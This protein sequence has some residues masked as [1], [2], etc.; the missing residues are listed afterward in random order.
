MFKSCSLWLALLL[1]PWLYGCDGFN[2]FGPMGEAGK[3][4]SADQ[5]RVE[6]LIANVQN[7][8]TLSTEANRY[9]TQGKPDAAV[10]L[11]KQAE[12]LAP[13]NGDIRVDLANALLAQKDVNLF[14]LQD[15]MTHL[16][17]TT[18]ATR[19]PKRMTGEVCSWD[20]ATATRSPFDVTAFD[21]YAMI[22]DPALQE[23]LALALDPIFQNMPY[24][25]GAQ[26]IQAALEARQVT[27]LPKAQ[28]VYATVL[29][30]REYNA[31]VQKG[32]EQSV[33]WYT[34]QNQTKTSTWIGICA[35]SR[36]Q[37]SAVIQR[38]Q[39]ALDQFEWAVLLL[40]DRAVRLQSTTSQALVKD[41][42]EGL[43]ILRRGLIEQQP[44]LG[45]ALVQGVFVSDLEA[46]Q[47]FFDA[48]G[49]T[50]WAKKTNWMSA[51]PVSTWFGVTVEQNRIVGLDLDSNQLSGVI[52][53]TF[54]QLTALK[55]LS[56]DRNQLTGTFPDALGTLT[57]LTYFSAADNALGGA[58][59]DAI[60]RWT[61]LTH[62][63]LSGQHFSGSLPQSWGQLL[64]L[65]ILNLAD[66]QLSGSIPSEWRNL[67]ALTAL[68]LSR[69]Q[70]SGTIPAIFDD[71]YALQTL[72][73][74][75]NQLSGALPASISQADRLR[76]LDLSDNQLSGSLPA[77]I[78]RLFRLQ[79]LRLHQNQFL[80]NV[81][82]A[83]GNLNELQ[84]L[85]LHQNQFSHLP[86]LSI[87]KTLKTLSIQQNK[88]GFG[89][90]IPQLGLSGLTF[91]PQ[92][93]I[94]TATT[95]EDEGASFTLSAPDQR[96]GN[97][98]E[99][100][101]NG[102]PLPNAAQATYSGTSKGIYWVE[103]RNPMIPTLV[104]Q[105]ELFTVR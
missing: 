31:I 7:P 70:F 29:V 25:N 101:L 6:A 51:Q 58:L 3:F 85:T 35:P 66:N 37:C 80:G 93:R 2:I 43:R 40:Q 42:E 19:I 17:T 8:Q 56:L 18:A 100:Y 5:A 48:A 33:A 92:K 97:Q 53:A 102:S 82:E 50:K 67:S 71:L 11:L 105:S 26:A 1:L 104:L 61:E 13:E 90:I 63:N 4:S 77:S 60:G 10:L 9:L 95:L 65:Q 68:D 89:S 64:K 76:L 28:L 87:L 16:Q 78:G 72:N 98:Y 96:A 69:N 79:T 30:M 94:G 57:S 99:W 62:L 84:T 39:D 54:G 59:P 88:L 12:T 44:C 34:I 47:S 55:H 75:G 83:V 45:S 15:L 36:L 20:G 49:G 103:I 81:P 27:D 24:Q 21:A 74:S 91:S 22:A 32:I 23:A 14:A 73:F 52:P 46:L 38:A 41:A 86:N